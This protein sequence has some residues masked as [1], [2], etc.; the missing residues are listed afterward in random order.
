ML[1]DV[2]NR[3]K[4]GARAPVTVVDNF[5]GIYNVTYTV[6]TLGTMLVELEVFKDRSHLDIY[7]GSS[8]VYDIDVRL[9]SIPVGGPYHRAFFRKV[10]CGRV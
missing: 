4:T 3:S 6:Y 2:L 5:N 8:D 10:E 1:A 9:N 7:I